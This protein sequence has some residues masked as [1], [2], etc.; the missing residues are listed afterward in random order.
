MTD[1][2]PYIP[3]GADLRITIGIAS[4]A[5]GLAWGVTGDHDSVPDLQVLSDGIEQSIDRA[6]L[7]HSTIDPLRGAS[8]TKG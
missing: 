4:Y 7:P 8:C 3:L 6:H 1:M 2:Y 5:G